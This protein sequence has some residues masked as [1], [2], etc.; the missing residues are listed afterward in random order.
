MQEPQII[1]L[2]NL[3]FF[4]DTKEASDK[5]WN[6]ITKHVQTKK[7]NRDQKIGED[8]ALTGKYL[9]KNGNFLGS[10]ILAGVSTE[11]G[12]SILQGVD[13]DLLYEDPQ[14]AKPL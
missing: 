12:K 4:K 6:K 13:K 7:A 5:L 3:G 1:D 8:L 14:A 11:I 9:E 10:Q 2:Q